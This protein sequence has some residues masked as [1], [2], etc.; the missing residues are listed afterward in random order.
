MQVLPTRRRSRPARGDLK[1]SRTDF[2]RE[3][4]SMKATPLKAIGFLAIAATFVPAYAAASEANQDAGVAVSGSERADVSPDYLLGKED[5]LDLDVLNFD[6]LTG[7]VTVRP[8]GKIS[9]K[10]LGDIQAEGRTVT[11]VQQ[12][13]TGKMKAYLPE[14]HVTLAVKQI[15]S[16][17]VYVMGRVTQPGMFNIGSNVNLLQA[18]AMAKGFTPWA[19]K[20]KVVIV[21]GVSGKRINVN[22]DKVVSGRQDNYLLYPGDTIVVP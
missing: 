2:E 22:F 1:Q 5:V 20:S 6:Q 7:P 3:M 16:M 12:E 4:R 17:K 19:K 8:D 10:L 11:D 14:P 15:N 13:I 9:V 18:L 21:R